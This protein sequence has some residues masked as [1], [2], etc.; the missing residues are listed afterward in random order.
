MVTE[1][2]GMYAAIKE[3]ICGMK[4]GKEGCGVVHECRVYYEVKHTAKAFGGVE[5]I[6]TV[7][8]SGGGGMLCVVL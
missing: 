6:G 5:K 2:G 3:L 4:E 7:M 8:G 1:G